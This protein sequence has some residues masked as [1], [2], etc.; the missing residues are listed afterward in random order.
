MSESLLVVLRR[1]LVWP[2]P[3]RAAGWV[4]LALCLTVIGIAAAQVHSF[5]GVA[6]V[7]IIVT[8]SAWALRALAGH[9]QPAHSRARRAGRAARLSGS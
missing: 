8:I 9:R 5:S 4:S 6:F 1:I 2:I 3:P 7:A